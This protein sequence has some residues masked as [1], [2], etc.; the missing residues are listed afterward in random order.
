MFF[1]A[2]NVDISYVLKAKLKEIGNSTFVQIESFHSYTPKFGE[3]K[4]FATDL[5]PGN[6][7]LSMYSV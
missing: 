4:I 7:M 2:E 5:V 3:T 6:A 1:C